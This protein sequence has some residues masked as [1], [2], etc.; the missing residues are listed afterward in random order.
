M[1]IE[2]SEGKADTQGQK[3]AALVALQ[4]YASH[5]RQAHEPV[6]EPSYE[7]EDDWEDALLGEASAPGSWWR[8]GA[9]GAV[10]PL[11]WSSGGLL[12][13][14]IE[15]AASERGPTSSAGRPARAARPMMAFRRASAGQPQTRSGRLAVDPGG[16]A[17]RSHG[18]CRAQQMVEECRLEDELRKGREREAK[19]RI[20]TEYD[21]GWKIDSLPCSLRLASKFDCYLL[22][23][24]MCGV[25]VEDGVARVV[26]TIEPSAAINLEY[27]SLALRVRRDEGREPFFSLDPSPADL[28]E[29]TQ[30]EEM[31]VK[32]FEPAWLAGTSVG[33]VLFQADYHLKE[34]SMGE[35]Q[36]PVVGMK[37]CFELAEA[38]G[39]SRKWSA[40]EWFKVQD[41]KVLVSEDHVLIPQVKLGVEAREQVYGKHGLEDA[42]VTRT[43]HP[44]AKYAE[45][46]TRN[47]ELIVERKSV[48][49]YLRELAKASV[50]AKFLVDPAIALDEQWFDT[51]DLDHQT[52]CLEVPQ[53]WNETLHSKIHLK[54]GI[55][56]DGQE[57]GRAEVRGVYG[58]VDLGLGRFPLSEVAPRDMA[59]AVG[60]R[61]PAY[62]GSGREELRS[63]LP[64]RPTS[65]ATT[66]ATPP[67]RAAATPKDRQVLVPVNNVLPEV[68]VTT[69]TSQAV[70]PAPARR[71]AR[72]TVPGGPGGPKHMRVTMPLRARGLPSM[73]APTQVG[74]RPVAVRPRGV[75]LNLDTFN[76]AEAHP[77]DTAAC[78]DSWETMVEC[79]RAAATI[80][81]QFWSNAGIGDGS[82]SAFPEQDKNLLSAVYHPCL[83]DRRGDGQHFLPL[84]PLSSDIAALKALL[85]DE[86]SVR[87]A[88]ERHFLAQGFSTEDPGA[89]FPASWK[90]SVGLIRSS[91]AE[92]LQAST[93]SRVVQ[94]RPELNATALDIMRSGAPDFDQNTEDGT[95]FRIY[96][97]GGVEVR[98]LHKHGGSESI[99]AVY[100]E[101]IAS[102]SL[103]L[104]R[105]AA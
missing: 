53:L 35:C 103:A 15:P 104:Q 62:L 99:G 22:P 63:S 102:K 84:D 86:D 66:I 61:R 73:I 45:D 21:I 60:A 82:Q 24:S 5:L 38:E 74:I 27:L 13:S 30:A 3:E 76:L 94:A 23:Q 91:A 47:M 11:Q 8:G 50:L 44:M 67:V 54:D 25:M 80:G 78:A 2:H 57:G 83:S 17:L 56:L 1:D 41:A 93:S 69:G 12:K 31:H 36:Q 29:A 96:N 16:L 59:S 48:I 101:A 89:L 79:A 75:D 9:P 14:G 95:K 100:S 71:G 77:V 37:S 105:G 70:V 58:G 33:E 7:L 43:S 42:P 34:L 65:L 40:R 51:S 97:A 52:C 10:Q 87:Q 19:T 32:R 46:F 64:M 85:K 90:S 18:E 4:R 68:V 88:R 26:P 72:P 6:E 81:T 98:T 92:G 20:R 39:F 28:D 55:I 49:Y